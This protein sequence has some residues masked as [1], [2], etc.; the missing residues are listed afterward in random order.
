MHEATKKILEDYTIFV[1]PLFI[2]Q[3]NHQRTVSKNYKVAKRY[4]DITIGLIVAT[5]GWTLVWAATITGI[6]VG[7]FRIGITGRCYFHYYYC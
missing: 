6:V 5:I 2:I 3:S 7:L 1:T 4:S